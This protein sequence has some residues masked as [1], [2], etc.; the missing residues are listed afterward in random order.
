M[1][2]TAKLISAVA[3]SGFM[4]GNVWA[5][6]NQ[7]LVAQYPFNGNAQDASGNRRHGTVH[8]ATLVKDRF[9]NPKSAYRFD[10]A[11]D[12]I[13]TPINAQ[14]KA[15]GT[16]SWS[17]WVRPTRVKYSQWQGIL[18]TDDSGWDR[19]LHI[20]QKGNTFALFNGDGPWNP[21]AVDVNQ[22]QHIVVMY[23]ANSMQFYKN[24]V[25]YQSKPAQGNQPTVNTLHIGHSPCA[26]CGNQSYQGDIDD[27]RIYNR[28]LSEAEIK[29]LHEEGSEV[30]K[31]L[32]KLN[33][34]AKMQE[35]QLEP[36]DDAIYRITV[37][38]TASCCEAR[39]VNAK[40]ALTGKYKGLA[41]KPSL[42]QFG[43]LGPKQSAQ[44][45]AAV[46]TQKATP[47]KAASLSM[48]FYYQCVY[49]YPDKA[50]KAFVIEVV[51]D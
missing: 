18:S 26:K 47:G 31:S 25:R 51:E 38:Q 12:Y 50:H 42:L 5:D 6:L 46:R 8:G 15:M 30:P 29:Q 19:A 20:P 1:K 2:N 4:A 41:L 24:G 22:W 34:T 16:T 36:D 13:Q 9:G 48:D 45:N 32:C 23:S 40:L 17:A 7:G 44:K 11:N 14:P 39:N 28:L 21:V 35:K 49:I 10:G 43:N 37:T 3:L 27:V 33:V